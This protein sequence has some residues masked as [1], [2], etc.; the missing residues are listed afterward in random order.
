MVAEQK[1][2]GGVGLQ[3]YLNLFSFTILG[4]G[5]LVLY[6]VVSILCSLLQLVPSYALA[7]W[8]ALPKDEQ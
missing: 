2:E 5:G 1:I 6:V 3:D 8:T 4:C 7:V